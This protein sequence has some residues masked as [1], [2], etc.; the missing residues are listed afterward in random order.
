ML[1]TE[2]K[3]PL[4]STSTRQPK[5]PSGS[6]LFQTDSKIN[7]SV[8]ST[9][10]QIYISADIEGYVYSGEPFDVTIHYRRFPTRPL[11]DAYQTMLAS[12]AVLSR[13]W[14]R[15]EEDEAWANL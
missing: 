4:R 1:E 11:S 9:G 8:T 10:M 13:D 5:L 14:D 15:P 6:D 12:E 2:I 7:I 3:A